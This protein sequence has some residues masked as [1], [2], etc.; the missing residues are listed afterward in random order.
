MIPCSLGHLAPGTRGNLVY[1]IYFVI[2]VAHASSLRNINICPVILSSLL[3]FGRGD[4]IPKPEQQQRGATSNL[5]VV[6]EVRCCPRLVSDV[7]KPRVQRDRAEV[8]VLNEGGKWGD[9]TAVKKGDLN[10][11]VEFRSG[12][13][14]MRF[15]A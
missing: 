2:R 6:R 14:A 1:V 3:G 8:A 9:Y 11:E 15:F 10:R 7:Q 12:R 13:L 4:A 5:T